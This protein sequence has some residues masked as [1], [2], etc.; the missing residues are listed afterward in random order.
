M[1]LSQTLTTE[2][3]VISFYESKSEEGIKRVLPYKLFEKNF[4]IKYFPR[5]IT[6]NLT[7]NPAINYI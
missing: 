5:M 2:E 1:G 6:I 7:M 3:E 4:I